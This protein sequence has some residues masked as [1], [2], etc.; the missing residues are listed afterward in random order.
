MDHTNPR[1]VLRMSLDVHPVGDFA[2]DELP[3][4]CFDATNFP[5]A[6]SSGRGYTVEILRV[7]NSVDGMDP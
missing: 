4:E 2:L 3:N 1:M 6:G 7:P 5:Q